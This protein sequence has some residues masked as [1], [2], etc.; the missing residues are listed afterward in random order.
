MGGGTL[1]GVSGEPPSPSVRCPQCGGENPPRSRF[2]NSCG[3]GLDDAEASEE[4]KLVSILFVDLVG[5]TGQS[6]QTDPEDVR[7]ALRLYYSKA[8]ECIEQHGGTVEKFIGDA[9]MGVFGAPGAQTEG[10]EGAVRAAV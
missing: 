8:K 10:A 5:F 7:D 9:V 4:R 6:H 3:A 2:C 1:R